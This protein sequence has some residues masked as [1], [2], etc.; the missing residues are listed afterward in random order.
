MAW[1]PT[2]ATLFVEKAAAPAVTD[3]Q[4]EGYLVGDI[5]IDETND[6]SYICLD[7]SVGA[8]VWTEI[9]G[10]GGGVT[11]HG[12]LT[13]LGDDDHSQYV[14][15]SEFTADSE[16]LVG[17]GAGTF[18]KES[19]ATLRTSI[20]VDAAGT[21][22]ALATK[23]P[24]IDAD[25]AIYRDSTAS[26]ALVTSTWTQ[27][28]AFLKTY[29]DTLYNKYV[30]PNHSGEV[31]SVADGAQ[32]I[33]NKQT[34]SA[35]APITLSNTPTV[36]AAAAPVIAIPAATN[37]VPGHATVA[38]IVAIEA[39]TLKATNVPT[40]LEVG[41]VNATTYGITSDGGADDIVLP[42]A[43][44]DVAGLL[45]ADKWDEIVANTAAKHTQ[46][47]DVALGAVGAK[48]P[49]IDADKT[50]YRD[51]TS[52]DALVTSTWTQVKAFLKT[53]FDTLYQVVNAAILKATFTTKGDI[54]VTTGASTPTRLA[55]GTDTHVLTAD[56]GE[57]SGVKWA[58]GGSNALPYVKVSDVKA[59]GTAGGTFTQDAWRTRVLNTEDNDADGICTLASNQITLNAGT[60]ECRITAPG[61]TVNRHKLKLRNVTGSTDLIIGT[62]GFIASASSYAQTIS[63]IVGRF[64]VAA[65][66]A[67]EVQ[68]Y[69]NTTK[70]ENG[71]GVESNFGV[72]EVY[73]VAEF[74]KVT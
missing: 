49:P 56:S 29:F 72:S 53:Y 31:T 22:S 37:A 7:I 26:D 11:D 66:Q 48:D 63:T 40:T 9:T 36:V 54:L 15:D 21:L 42:E 38:H 23:N 60:Y 50:L 39:N 52:S 1:R 24:P 30:H 67:L 65:S 61:Y 68:H 18:Q 16:I 44:T 70:T 33:A 20:G 64:T 34:L 8:A 41:T 35:T 45:G 47:S 10:A 17:T 5:W 58:A 51:S 69:C 19:G 14:K 43:T 6:K 27:M 25:K 62:S 2:G 3:D 32:T 55:V 57:A 71:F 46:G 74:W 28:K 12:A 73:T 59:A 4:N 13:G